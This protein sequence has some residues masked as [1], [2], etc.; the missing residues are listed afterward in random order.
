M[1]LATQVVIYGDL[2]LGQ[3][4]EPV[5]PVRS[6]HEVRCYATDYLQDIRA[7]EPVAFTLVDVPTGTGTAILR[8]S[9]GRENHLQIVPSA[10]KI[11]GRGLPI[12]TNWAGDRQAGR[13]MFFGTIEVA[14]PMEALRGTNQVEITYPDAGG[15][16]ACVVLQVNREGGSW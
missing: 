11:N 7:D 4:F 6:V 13:G 14:V 2:T 1:H 10:V 12:P 3:T 15:K 8:L 16:V 9:A 5:S